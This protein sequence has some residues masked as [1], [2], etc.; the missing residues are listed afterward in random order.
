MYELRKKFV[1]IKE[2]KE[3]K[4]TSE[5]I[6]EENIKSYNQT[7]CLACNSIIKK[8]NFLV[9]M[10]CLDFGCDNFEKQAIK[11]EFRRKK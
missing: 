2:I 11:D 1:K 9:C 5:N 3:G 10:D 6:M 7:R 4:G 8:A